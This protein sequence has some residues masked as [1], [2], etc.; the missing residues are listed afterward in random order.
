MLADLRQAV[1]AEHACAHRKPAIADESDP[2]DRQ[3]LC[4]PLRPAV[5]ERAHDRT[6][7][8]RTGEPTRWWRPS[9][10]RPSGDAAG[11][12][13]GEPSM[14]R[15]VGQIGV[16]GWIIVTPTLL[17]LFLGRWLD[18][19][20]GTAVFWSAPLLM[21][22][23]GDRILVGLAMDAHAMIELLCHR[24]YP[25]PIALGRRRVARRRY[26]GRRAAFSGLAMERPAVRERPLSRASRLALQLARFAVTAGA[27]VIIA[28]HFGAAALLIA[29]VGI[30]MARTVILRSGAPDDPIPARH[31]DA[32]HG[33]AGAIHRTGGGDLG[34]HGVLAL[35]GWL[36]TRSLKL[37]PSRGQAA[38]ELIVADDR[39]ANSRHDACRRPRHI[40]RCSARCLSSSWRRTG[41]RWCR[42]ST[43]RP[44]IL[45]PMRRSRSSYSL[46]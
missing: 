22:G 30:L 17:G 20:F 11:C 46:P 1:D 44:P 32:V 41:R 23:V 36:L 28:R 13:E 43:R 12:D 4:V 8:R 7:A 14:V 9:G 40:C 31:Q 3:T 39:G 6:I 45:R 10:G 16:L 29:T 27:L 15:F 33:R 37:R 5:S 25:A 19:K 34:H 21:L 18:H 38:I 42:A 35:V 26:R 2:S 24:A